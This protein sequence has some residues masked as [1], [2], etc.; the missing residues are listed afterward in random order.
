MS[1]FSNSQTLY[2]NSLATGANDGT[3]WQ[4]AYT[5]LQAATDQATSGSILVAGGVYKPND[6]LGR[7]SH[8]RLEPNVDLIGGYPNFGNPDFDDRDWEAF[9]TIL[10]GDI[11]AENDISDNAYT[12]LELSSTSHFSNDIE[13]VNFT[14]ANGVSAIHVI[15]T[16]D[17]NSELGIENCF[18]N[19]NLSETEGG[20]IFSENVD[21]QIFSSTFSNNKSGFKGGAISISDAFSEIVICKFENNYAEF[22]GGAISTSGLRDTTYFLNTIFSKNS[23]GHEGGAIETNGNHKYFNCLFDENN[24]A[25]R[26][27]VFD[28]DGNGNVEA[29]NC[30]FVNNQTNGEGSLVSAVDFF[31]KVE[32]FN[33]ILFGNKGDGIF[34]SGLGNSGAVLENCLIEEESCPTNVS[35]GAIM[36]YNKN[37]LFI[38]SDDFQLS[39]NSPCINTGNNDFLLDFLEVDILLNERIIGENVDMG[40]FEYTGVVSTSEN[41]IDQDIIAFP[42]PMNEVL[43]IKTEKGL[44]EESNISLFNF[45]GKEIFSE[46][47]FLIEGTNYEMDVSALSSGVFILKV[48]SGNTIF[49]KKIIK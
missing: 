49:T 23:A 20:A 46:S 24:A 41:E 45:S 37:P 44:P 25:S 26:G 47:I 31:N 29:T 13:G 3:S 4:N 11:G 42:N 12:I 34:Y 38:G 33:S 14:G 40:A 43:T 35:C 21:V 16:P 9:P 7:N 8:F 2:V 5:D 18:F 19:N 27:G 36:L 1:Y 10:S 48:A 22:E 28:I 6:R 39:K 17:D 15:G 30:T 32:I